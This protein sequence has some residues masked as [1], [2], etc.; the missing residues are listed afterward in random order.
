MTSEIIKRKKNTF[1]N[2]GLETSHLH[3]AGNLSLRLHRVMIKVQS[4]RAIN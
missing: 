3:V 4:I 2:I 1:S